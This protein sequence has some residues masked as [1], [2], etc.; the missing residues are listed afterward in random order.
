MGYEHQCYICDEMHEHNID[1][2]ICFDC[3]HSAYLYTP[4]QVKALEKELATLKDALRWRKWPEE[5]PEAST[6]CLVVTSMGERIIALLAYGCW[7]NPVTKKSIPLNDCRK[8]KVT[9]WRPLGSMP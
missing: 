2:E 8:E 1:G 9:H 6:L 4:N 5:K 3:Q 7:V